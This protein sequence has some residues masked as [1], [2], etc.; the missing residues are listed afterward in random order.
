MD[1]A[2]KLAQVSFDLNEVPVGAIVVY[3]DQVIGQGYN[4]KELT[5]NA[6]AHAE[7]IALNQAQKYLGSWRLT[8]CYVYTSLEPCFMCAAALV[9]TRIS[10]LIFAA[11]DKKFG[12]I[13]SIYEMSRDKRLNHNFD[14]LSGIKEYESSNLLKKFFRKIRERKK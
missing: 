4:S 2:L 14:F 8:D 13:V 9:H 3:K 6:L 7:I 12:G 1:E 11:S 10:G 5:Q